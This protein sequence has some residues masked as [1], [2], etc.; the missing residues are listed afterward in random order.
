MAKEPVKPKG[1]SRKPQLA[2][3]SL[4]ERALSPEQAREKE[5]VQV[6]EPKGAGIGTF[7]WSVWSVL[8]SLLGRTADL[9]PLKMGNHGT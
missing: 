4:F 3:A 1:R 2:I 8:P 9:K 5:P 7:D 6:C